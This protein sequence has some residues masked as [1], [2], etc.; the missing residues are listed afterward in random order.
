MKCSPYNIYKIVAPFYQKLCAPMYWIY[1][2]FRRLFLRDSRYFYGQYMT[3]NSRLL[4]LYR[5]IASPER[6]LKKLAYRQ[7]MPLPAALLHGQ[8]LPQFEVTDRVRETATALKRDGIV[9]LPGLL[10]ELA[11][12]VL[13]SQ[14]VNLETL[15][16]S[17]DYSSQ[18]VRA[19]DPQILSFITHPMILEVFALYYKRQPYFRLPPSLTITYPDIDRKT[20]RD[21]NMRNEPL[22]MGW[23]F[24]TVNML[25]A[26]MLCNDVSEEDS[27]MIQVRGDHRRHRINLRN[28]DYYYSDEFVRD[29]Y[30][31]VHCCGPKGTVYLFDANALHALHVVS[32]R[33]RIDFKIMFTLGNDIPP[34]EIDDPELRMSLDAQVDLEGLA[35]LQRN[36]FRF[37][38]SE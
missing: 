37:V 38:H 36:A 4:A 32:G 20:S 21:V 5:N 17:S 33:L 31:L 9:V 22:N 28:D 26:A 6:F 15:R 2:L 35:E 1:S 11:D 24:D 34:R 13:N 27:H 10:P 23:H 29:H 7:I 8:P 14:S 12:H 16:P 25:Q 30:Q 18:I 19:I 3:S